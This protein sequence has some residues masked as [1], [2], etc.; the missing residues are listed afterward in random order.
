MKFY[1]DS[2]DKIHALEDV[3]DEHFLPQG[4]MPVTAEEAEAITNP[5]PTEEQIKEATLAQMIQIEDANKM[6]RGEREAWIVL[7]KAT[8]QQQN[9]TE[10]QLYAAN[11]F[12][13]KLIDTDNQMANLRDLL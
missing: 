12:F 3:K 10:Q 4:C 2:N 6:T 11:K 9:V 7:L 13:K 5:P 8:A 1:K